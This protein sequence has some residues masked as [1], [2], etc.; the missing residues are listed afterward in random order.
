MILITKDIQPQAVL[1][2]KEKIPSEGAAW[3]AGRLG[4]TGT[5]QNSGDQLRR[6][7]GITFAFLKKMHV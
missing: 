4:Q 2:K 1:L 5:A 7:A 6:K 3:I